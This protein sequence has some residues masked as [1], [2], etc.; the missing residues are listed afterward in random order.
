MIV[1]IAILAIL[2]L[3]AVPTYNVV[4]DRI[5]QSTYE[6]KV[7]NIISHAETFAENTNNFVFDV[8]TLIEQG[9]LEADNEAGEYLD[10]RN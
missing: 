3:I 7:Q 9:L 1:V 2:I 6:S 10:P 4:S 8:G 5:K